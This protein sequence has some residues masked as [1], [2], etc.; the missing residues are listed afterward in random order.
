LQKEPNL[1]A[2]L[3][4]FATN[5]TVL[6]MRWQHVPNLVCRD[7]ETAWT[8]MCVSSMLYNHVIIVK[9]NSH[10][11]LPSVEVMLSLKPTNYDA[12]QVEAFRA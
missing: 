1:K 11:I 5:T 6:E 9:V 10:T 3:E 8:I 4:L 7:V 2:R 12:Q